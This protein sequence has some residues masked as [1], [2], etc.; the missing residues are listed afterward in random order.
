MGFQ[1]VHAAAVMSNVADVPEPLKLLRLEGEHRVVLQILQ[2][3]RLPL[4]EGVDKVHN[5]EGEWLDQCWSDICCDY[6]TAV[7]AGG[8]LRITCS[9]PLV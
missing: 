4:L 5:A 6:L 7:T 1:L 8:T 9:K 2:N 3:G